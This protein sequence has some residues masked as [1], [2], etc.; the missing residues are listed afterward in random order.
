ML[1]G[2]HISTTHSRLRPG[3][4]AT[5]QSVALRDSAACLRRPANGGRE[6]TMAFAVLWERAGIEP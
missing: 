6:W 5:R 2:N 1:K 4:S 3:S